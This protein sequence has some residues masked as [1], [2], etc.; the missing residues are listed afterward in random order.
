[1]THEDERLAQPGLIGQPLPERERLLHHADVAAGDGVAQVFRPQSAE[2]R[3][4]RAAGVW[5]SAM[6]DNLLFLDAVGKQHLVDAVGQLA[7]RSPGSTGSLPSLLSSP[8]TWPG[9]GE[10]SRMR[11]PI[12]TASGIEWVTNSTVKR[13]SAHSCSSSSCILRRVSASSAA[14]GSS[15]SSTSGSIASARAMATRCFMP[16]DSVCG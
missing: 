3:A 16:P 14:N 5:M 12:S 10:S 13:V 2:P 9:C 11:L 1:M 8:L 4:A 7:R 6:A 15:I